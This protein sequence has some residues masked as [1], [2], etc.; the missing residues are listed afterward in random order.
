M[1]P[2]SRSTGRTSASTRN[3]TACGCSP[4]FVRT[5]QA[6]GLVISRSLRRQPGGEPAHAS[7]A[8]QRI[9]AGEQGRGF[10]AVATE[11]RT[12]AAHEIK[13][14]I[15]TRVE[16]VEQGATRVDLAGTT[17]GKVIAAVEGLA[18]TAGAITAASRQEP[19]GVFQ[20]NDA[21]A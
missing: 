3:R 9:A 19:A 10:A 4:E 1:Q 21:V 5:V 17:M 20:V 13:A 12:L 18:D 16:R 11:V 8:T 6:S 7:Q 15:C 2:S 14:L